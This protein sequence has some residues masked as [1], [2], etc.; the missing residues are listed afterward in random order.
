MENKMENKL[1][2]VIMVTDD[3]E[4]RECEGEGAVAFAITDDGKG[5]AVS[6]C[7]RG[8]FSTNSVVALFTVLEDVFKEEW[9]YAVLK[10]CLKGLLDAK[11]E[12]ANMSSSD[13]GKAACEDGGGRTRMYKL[14]D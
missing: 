7:V 14:P 10:V 12:A 3:G 5:T 8:C 11:P 2:K 6:S 13:A 4:R 9:K 1:Q